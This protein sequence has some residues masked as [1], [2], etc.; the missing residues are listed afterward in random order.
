MGEPSAP[1]GRGRVAAVSRYGSPDWPK[2]TKVRLDTLLAER[3][4]FASRSRRRRRC[5]P[6]RCGWA[7]S[8]GAPTS[9]ASSWPRRRRLASTRCPEFVSRGGTQARQRAR[10]ARD[11]PRRAALPGRRRVDRRLHRLPAPARRGAR[12]RRSTSPTASCTGA[13]RTDPRVTVLERTNARALEPAALPYAPGPDRDRRLVHLAGEGAARG[14]RLRGARAST[15]WR[16][17]SRSSRSAA[18]RS[19][20]AASFATRRCGGPPWWRRRG[21]AAA[22]RGSVL[23]YASSG[24][25]GPKGNLRDVRLAR[26]DRREGGVADLEAAAR[27]V[28]P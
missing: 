11:R 2:A 28:E 21:G 27:E 25:P 12:G 23:G 18:S 15:A 4:L 8:A 13:L 19:A 14:A 6:A 26:R 22:R 3:G 20:R 10:G 1:F 7:P 17:S 5:W 16:W 9:P 24:L